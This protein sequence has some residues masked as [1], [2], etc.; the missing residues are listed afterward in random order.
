MILSA[1]EEE[2]RKGEGRGEEEQHC[3]GGQGTAVGGGK[4]RR[5]MV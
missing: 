5:W 1:Q 3:S 2:R 4:S